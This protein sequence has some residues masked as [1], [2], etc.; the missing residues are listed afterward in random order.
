MPVS[1]LEYDW[2]GVWHDDQWMVKAGCR[3]FTLAEA[4]S[5]WMDDSYDRSQSVKSTVGFA[6]KWLAEQEPK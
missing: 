6:L 4:K 3:W 5:H 2:F 1:D